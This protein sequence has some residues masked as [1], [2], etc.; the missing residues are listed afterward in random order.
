MKG[1]LLFLLL[2]SF[3]INEVPKCQPNEVLDEQTQKCEQFCE[4]GEVFNLETSSCESNNTNSTTPDP[5]PDP[6]PAPTSA[7]TPDPTPAPT[8]DPIPDPTPDPT[9]GPTPDLQK[10]CKNGVNAFVN[11]DLNYKEM[12]VL[13]NVLEGE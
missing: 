4:I 3:V 6:T 7:P 8:P 12:N 10:K 11:L 2:I 5:T 9:P 13:I 1:F